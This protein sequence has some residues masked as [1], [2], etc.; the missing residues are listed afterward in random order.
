M[1]QGAAV[2]RVRQFD[3]SPWRWLAYLSLL[4]SSFGIA[5]S[6]LPLRLITVD[7]APAN[8]VV[9]GQLQGYA[10]D[11]V[12]AIQQQLGDTTSI[13]VLP[14]DQALHVADTRP[15]VLLFSFSRTHAR[16]N[17]YIWLLPV[18]RKKWQLFMPMQRHGG[19]TNRIRS[20]SDFASLAR[21]GVVRGDVREAYLKT[22]GLTNLV[23][24][25]SPQQMLTLLQQNQL[26]AIISS[27]MEID[28]LWNQFEFSG[29]KPA[30]RLSFGHSDAYLLFSKD[31]DP[32]LVAKWQKALSQLR[33]Q[34]VLRKI[35]MR[36]QDKLT[37]Y[38]GQTPRLLPGDWLEY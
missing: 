7:E 12:Q 9:N 2:P 38:S 19:D 15:N 37:Q 11:I 1:G 10:T 22:L 26:D 8:F 28:M 5:S 24:A 34:G 17:Q 16:E 29:V 20:E 27:Q 32:A 23:S 3:N 25:S 30:A 36:W 21:L 4:W 13:E 6:D 18:L 31:T 14:E 33:Q 35:A